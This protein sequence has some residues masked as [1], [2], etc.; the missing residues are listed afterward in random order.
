MKAIEARTREV[1]PLGELHVAVYTL[2]TGAF[3]R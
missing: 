3:V 2:D 1:S